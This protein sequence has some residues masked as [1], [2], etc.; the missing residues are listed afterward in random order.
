MAE[1]L[2][3]AAVVAMLDAVAQAVVDQADVLT[4]ADLAIGDGDHG[5][6]MKRGF[7]A[8]RAALDRLPHHDG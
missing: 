7:E 1:T 5:T 6:G 4:D 3:A 8:A 2:D